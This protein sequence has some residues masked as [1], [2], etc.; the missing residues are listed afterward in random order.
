MA[1]LAVLAA[2]CSKEAP[3]P[4]A[5]K[6][7]TESIQGTYDL[8]D[9]IAEFDAAYRD[10]KLNRIEERRDL[11]DYGSGK[12]IYVFQDDRL[13]TYTEVSSL[14]DVTVPG[15]GKVHDVRIDLAFGP[16]GETTRESK[17]VDGADEPLDDLDAAGV[18]RRAE[19]LA[20]QATLRRE[21]PAP[22]FRCSADDA[23]WSLTVAGTDGTLT[24]A[25]TP[26]AGRSFSARWQ[27]D[28]DGAA[29]V[30]VWTGTA[31]DGEFAAIEL[32]VSEEHCA[33]AEGRSATIRLPDDTPSKGCCRR[34]SG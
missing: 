4:P 2:G 20:A 24:T 8:G 30:L 23:S 31:T 33:D 12:S 10:G 29:P 17:T 22:A 7:K 25:D 16:S 19:A 26:D 18:R 5:P 14:R 6:V 13:A 3:P 34:G 11:G 27:W 15:T 1:T 9:T 21:R 32:R 28:A